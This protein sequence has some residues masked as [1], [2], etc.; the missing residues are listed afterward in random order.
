[1]DERT[2]FEEAIRNH[3][4]DRE[5]FLVYADYL[6]GQGDPWGELIA[7]MIE[8]DGADGA[9]ERE[10]RIR[11]SQLFSTNGHFVDDM[12]RELATVEWHWGFIRSARFENNADWMD[13]KWDLVPVVRQVLD[14]PQAILLREL[15]I[16]VL[17]WMQQAEDATRLL[18]EV[19]SLG[20]ASG[21]QELH[22]GDVNDSIDLAH[23]VL[24]ALDIIGRDYRAVRNLSVHG[25]EFDLGT[26]DLPE[27]QILVVETC[28]LTRAQL[29][30]IIGDG[31]R[32]KLESLEVWFGSSDYGAEATV[33]DIAPLL[34][35]KHLPRVKHLGLMNAEIVEDVCRVLP[36]ASI[37][38]QLRSLDLSMG[39]LSDS[40]IEPLLQNRDAF[41]HLVE[42]NVDDNYLSEAAVES[43]REAFGDA[44]V[45]SQSKEEDEYEGVIYRYVSQ[46]E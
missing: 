44:V 2:A 7:V 12:S 43:L 21:I 17:R 38:A 24:G 28:G 5:K 10:L 39:T 4:D 25:Y 37:L 42:L 31:P 26:L 32:E 36:H 3:P 23:H 11:Q 6:Q 29:R 14:R 33:D 40:G 8:A 20:L 9:R 19:S 15:R 34:D 13:D 18:E 16:G 27:L 45:W 46:W 41:S 1:M 35:A 22:V 30:S